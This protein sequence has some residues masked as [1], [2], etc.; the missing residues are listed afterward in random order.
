M[1]KKTA[2]TLIEEIETG[3]RLGCVDNAYFILN[4]R[5]TKVPLSI[6]DLAADVLEGGNERHE[7]AHHHNRDVDDEQLLAREGLLEDVCVIS[8]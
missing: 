6:A 4:Q 7:A 8:D 1:T 2:Q 5:R 3:G